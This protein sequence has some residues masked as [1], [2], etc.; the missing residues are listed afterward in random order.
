M[1]IREVIQTILSYHP[2]LFDYQ[3]CDD[4][5][6]GDPDVECTGI[7]TAIS[8]TIEVIR[9]AALLGANLIVTHEPTFYTSEDSPGWFEDFPNS[10]YEE[11][12]ALLARHGIVIW[13]DHDHLH[14]HQPDG[15]FEGVL[16]YTG[17]KPYAKAVRPPY[18]GFGHFLIELPQ[19]MSVS[20]VADHLMR[21]IG[22]NGCRYVGRPDD[23]I[24]KILIVGHLYPMMSASSPSRR[25]GKPKEYSVQIIGDMEDGVDLI[26]PGETIDWT[27]LSYIRD[28]NEL[29]HS[30][31]MISLGHYNWESLGMRYAADW[32]KDLIPA[33][34]VTFV[35]AGDL[36]RYRLS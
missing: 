32:L 30:K 10:V 17:W 28:A 26:L 2:F 16:R 12:A 20:A 5:K 33:L 25:D 9:Q 1:T 35:D 24:R 7:V 13:R 3:G 11:K 18:G 14:F 31:A 27:V 4:F 29:G 6:C 22:M 19:P 23:M 34:P 8:P 36:F 15:I 21:C